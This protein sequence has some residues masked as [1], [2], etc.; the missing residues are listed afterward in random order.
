MRCA[1][2]FCD[3]KP[4]T[5]SADCDCGACFGGRCAPRPGVCGPLQEP[6]PPP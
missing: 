4:C 6:S 5:T 3:A 2:E 1:G